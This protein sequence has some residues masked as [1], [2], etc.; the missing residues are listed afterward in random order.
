MIQ[1]F[2]EKFYQLIF[3]LDK[4]DPIWKSKRIRLRFYKDDGWA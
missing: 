3:N 1:E 2:N 4:T